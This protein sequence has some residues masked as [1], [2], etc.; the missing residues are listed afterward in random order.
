MDDRLLRLEAASARHDEQ[1]AKLFSKIH[2]LSEHL[3]NIQNTLNQI[4]W[5]AVGMVAYYTLSE[6][7]F[8]AAI[9]IAETIA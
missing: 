7:G 2:D 5:I 8:F 1:I 4:K 9:K 3:Q 6:V